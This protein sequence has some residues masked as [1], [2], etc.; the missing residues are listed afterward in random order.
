MDTSIPA[1]DLPAAAAEKL[2][3]KKHKKPR[4]KEKHLEALSSRAMAL[5]DTLAPATDAGTPQPQPQAP[6]ADPAS[7]IASPD[8]PAGPPTYPAGAYSDPDIPPQSGHNSSSPVRDA[9]QM[10]D[11]PTDASDRTGLSAPA[12]AVHVYEQPDA[13]AYL[14]AEDGSG[15]PSRSGLVQEPVGALIAM[16]TEDVDSAN[17]SH[18][19]QTD[20][21]AGTETVNQAETHVEHAERDMTID[22]AMGQV[23]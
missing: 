20:T 11:R 4:T 8:A 5:L 13:P 16:E 12:E 23:C 10:G 1:Q 21:G 22:S 18:G 17:H 7:S 6:A 14:P 2:P 15:S 3:A 19:R 9:A